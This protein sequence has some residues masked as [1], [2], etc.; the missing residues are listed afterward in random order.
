VDKFYM[1][2]QISSMRKALVD[3][4]AGQGREGQAFAGRQVVLI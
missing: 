1:T 2:A 3:H 4:A